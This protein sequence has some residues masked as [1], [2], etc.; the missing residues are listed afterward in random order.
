M[1]SSGT[2]HTHSAHANMQAEYGDHKIKQINPFKKQIENS[3]LFRDP[4]DEAKVGAP[5]TSPQ[6]LRPLQ[7]VNLLP[8]WEGDTGPLSKPS[9]LWGQAW[10]GPAPTCW[11]KTVGLSC[12]SM[13]IEWDSLTA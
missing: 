7:G 5:D 8:R 6:A 12:L 9:T 13:A 1:S 2:G 11:S 10:G 3:I 4:L